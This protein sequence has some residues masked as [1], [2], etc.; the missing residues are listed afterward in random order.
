[1]KECDIYCVRCGKPLNGEGACYSEDDPDHEEALCL[2][3]YKRYEMK[4]SE[5]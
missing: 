2:D 4:E 3:C 5:D 1:M